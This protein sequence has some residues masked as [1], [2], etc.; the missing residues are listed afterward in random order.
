M[1]W[2]SKRAMRTRASLSIISVGGACLLFWAQLIPGW[3][4]F[5]LIILW[6]PFM[7]TELCQHCGIP[8][9]FKRFNP[10]ADPLICP[11]CHQELR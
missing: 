2:R 5:G 7:I 3:V 11:N 8:L 10:F 6:M 9:I 4:P 1:G